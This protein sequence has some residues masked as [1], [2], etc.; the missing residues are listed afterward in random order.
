MEEFILAETGHWVAINKPPGITSEGIYSEFDSM[1]IMVRQFYGNMEGQSK[2]PAAVNRIDRP[3][4]GIVLF[5]K[6]K[7]ALQALN[8]TFAERKV[9]KH[10]LAIVRHEGGTFPKA[11]TLIHGY[12]KRSGERKPRISFPPDHGQLEAKLWYRKLAAFGHF[13]LLQI[14]LFTGRYHQIRAQMAF[15]GMPI[16]NDRLYGSPIEFDL[17]HIALHA[18]KLQCMD[19][20][21]GNPINIL[22]PTPQVPCWPVQWQQKE[23]VSEFEDIPV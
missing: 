11:D 14:R 21:S 13:T 20:I 17:P 6:Q 8:Q 15:A 22:A 10:Y 16:R 1:E 12:Q 9:Q 18:W 23:M 5:A 3:T 2:F 19:P 4:S 7:K